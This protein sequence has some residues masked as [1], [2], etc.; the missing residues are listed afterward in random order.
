MIHMVA[1]HVS[2]LKS[3]WYSKD[4]VDHC[5]GCYGYVKVEFIQLHVAS[6]DTESE[7]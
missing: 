2:V 5:K 6:F 7:Q 4:T 1:E 3:P